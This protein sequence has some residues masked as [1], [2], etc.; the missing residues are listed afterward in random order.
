M[1]FEDEFLD[2]LQR[3]NPILHKGEWVLRCSGCDGP[4]TERVMLKLRDRLWHTNCLRCAECGQP[5]T[6]KCY[7][8]DDAHYCE[9]HFFRRYGTRCQ[10][11]GRGVLPLETVRRVRQW[12]FHLQCFVCS[13]C[14]RELTTG[15][16][17][18]LLEDRKLVCLE[19][20]ATIGTDQ[21]GN[22]KRPRT[23]INSSQLEAL[24]AA[25]RR[26]P[27]PSR[28]VREQLSLETGLDM[29]VVQVWFQNK[30]AKDKRM[31]KEVKKPHWDK[32]SNSIVGGEALGT[33]EGHSTR[34]HLEGLSGLSATM[35]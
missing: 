23:S 1:G 27:K 5:L 16:Q 22:N 31:K 2:L 34:V 8:R 33:T 10:G 11:C 26:S 29:R 17:F 32:Q 30:R 25:Y 24:K 3:N 21:G 7:H 19:D 18:Y 28:H 35:G 9:E 6:H 13:L 4:L 14:G 20:Y 12:V 15:D